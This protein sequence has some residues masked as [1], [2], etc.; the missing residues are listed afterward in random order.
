[1]LG[2][3][4]LPFYWPMNPPSSRVL[5]GMEL[6]VLRFLQEFS[7]RAKDLLRPDSCTPTMKM[8]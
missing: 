6:L 1:M 7:S 8:V 2:Q 4:E 5:S 3:K